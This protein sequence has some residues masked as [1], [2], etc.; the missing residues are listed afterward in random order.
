MTSFRYSSSECRPSSTIAKSRSDTI[1]GSNADLIPNA[2][3]IGARTSVSIARTESPRSDAAVASAALTVVVPTPPLPS[4]KTTRR[5]R[6][7]A[8]MMR[9]DAVMAGPLP[10]QDVGA[11][12]QAASARAQHDEIVVAD[13]LLF[14]RFVK[15]DR[16]RCGRRVS[17]LLD[18]G[19]N[20][21]R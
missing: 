2:F 11:P 9:G 15:R 8:S 10:S 18:V 3:A 20:F 4:R 6:R 13:A 14:Q 21:F 5:R 16:N 1:T 19:E 17:I 12:G 7:S